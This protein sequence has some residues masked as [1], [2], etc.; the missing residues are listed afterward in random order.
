MIMKTPTPFSASKFASNNGPLLP[1]GSD[2]PCKFG[3]DTE[4][5]SNVMPLGSKQ[6]LS[7]VGGATH[8]GGSCQVSITYDAAP[9]KSSKFKVI[10]SIIGGCPARNAPGNIGTS[11][12]TEDPDK[13]EFSIPDNLPSGDAVL[14]WTWFNKVGNREMYMNCAPVKLTGGGAAKR[15]LKN[16]TLIARGMEAYEALP[17][18]FVANIGN[19]CTTKDNTDLKFDNPGTSVEMISSSSLAGPV[20]S[21]ASSGK[22]SSTNGVDV[23]GAGTS[24]TNAG[25]SGAGEN[26]AGSGSKPEPS[27]D[28]LGGAFYTVTLPEGPKQTAASQ[29]DPP[30]A[31]A[32]EENPTPSAASTDKPSSA[33]STEDPPMLEDASPSASG[34]TTNE[35]SGVGSSQKSAGSQC[36]NEGAWN[37]IDGNSYQ[38]CASGTWSVIMPLAAGT[39]CNSITADHMVIE[40]KTKRVTRAPRAHIRRHARGMKFI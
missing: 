34:S 2:Y 24:G 20:G 11:A 18:M 4:G 38:R 12:T 19:G 13:Y 15:D 7:F 22:L 35:A 23:A 32:P 39:K 26:A 27:K 14:A 16:E 6:Q 28:A 8:G 3:Y 1:D 36:S 21:C 29:V 9:S 37:C 40:A 17:D 31:K 25:A 30:A 5:A 33:P 10:H